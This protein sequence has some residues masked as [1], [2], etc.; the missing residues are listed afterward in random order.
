MNVFGLRLKTLMLAGVLILVVLALFLYG[1]FTTGTVTHGFAV[2]S[3][4]ASLVSVSGGDGASLLGAGETKSVTLEIRNNGTI[5]GMTDNVRE[6]WM[7]FT[8]IDGVDGTVLSDYVE[9]HQMFTNVPAGGLTHDICI[10][11]LGHPQIYKPYSNIP[12]DYANDDPY[13]DVVVELVVAVNSPKCNIVIV[14]KGD[15]P[16]IVKFD[17]RVVAT[18]EQITQDGI[19]F[20]EQQVP[21]VYSKWISFNFNK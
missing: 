7:R 18:T 14:D 3:A 6:Q 15:N 21:R 4:V 20:V 13:T 1:T 10:L 9:V 17:G 12:Q 16:I 19:Y 11:I 2:P 8:V 5:L